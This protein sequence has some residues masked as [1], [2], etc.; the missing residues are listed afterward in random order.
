GALLALPP[1]C[2]VHVDRLVLYVLAHRG[3]H[4]VNDSSDLLLDGADRGSADGHAE[5]VVHQD[6]NLT[7]AQPVGASKHGDGGLQP[8]SLAAWWHP[9][10]QLGAGGDAAAGAKQAVPLVL[11]DDGL[12]LGQ[13]QDLMTQRLWIVAGQGLAAMAAGGRLADEGLRRRQQ[14]P[15]RTR[16]SG[17][18]APWT[19]GR[20]AGWGRFDF[21]ASGRGGLGR[22][23]G[24][25][26][27]TLFQL[28]NVLLQFLQAQLVLGED[29]EQSLL[30][31]RWDL[32]PHFTRDRGHARHASEPTPQLAFLQ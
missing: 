28:G 29:D 13:F 24:V 27:Q 17:L 12:D 31:R 19:A 6:L 25:G 30:D 14:W 16:V 11:Q 22:V 15:C 5:E 7:L 1:R 8:G 4:W 23:A 2:L 9:L 10:G 21:G 3:D 32:F 26:P 18:T 20:G